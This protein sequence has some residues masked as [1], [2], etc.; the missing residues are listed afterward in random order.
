[1]ITS[2]TGRTGAKVFID[3][4]HIRDI[5]PVF[6]K[7]RPASLETLFESAG[8]LIRLYPH[9]FLYKEGDFG[10]SAFVLIS[11]KVELWSQGLGVLGI[12][13]GGDT[14]G[15][16]GIVEGDKAVIRNADG[17]PIR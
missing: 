3:P 12:F 15:E 7:L 6:S 8:E 17:V 16:E 5:H 11:G 9:H 10:Y 2:T 1:M 14:V 4:K 13:V